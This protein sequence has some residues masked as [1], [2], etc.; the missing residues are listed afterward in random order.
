MNIDEFFKTLK[1]KQ[2]DFQ[3]STNWW[4]YTNNCTCVTRVW[5]TALW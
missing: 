1:T 3:S 5:D 4:T 2:E